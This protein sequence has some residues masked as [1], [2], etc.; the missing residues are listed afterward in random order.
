MCMSR[1]NDD[2]C[3][4][5]M[6]HN[7]CHRC[8]NYIDISVY[9]LGILIDEDV[10]VTPDDFQG[11]LLTEPV[12]DTDWILLFSLLYIIVVS[13]YLILKHVL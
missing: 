2:L 13:V 7:S 10:L 4:R 1:F 9:K 12:P 6:Q 8:I 5:M 3:Y 11:P